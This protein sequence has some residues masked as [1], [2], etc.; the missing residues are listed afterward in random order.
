MDEFAQFKIAAYG[1]WELFLHKQQF[2]YVGRCYAAAI[3]PSAESILDMHPWEAEELIGKVVPAWNKAVKTLFNHDWP[4][5]AILGNDWRHLH[6][7]LIPRY[8]TPR[9]AHGIEFV[10][11]RPKGNYAPY[12]KKEIPLETLLAIKEEIRSKL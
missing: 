1:Y 10:D 6:A 5:V 9:T 2:P 11:P 4:N 7:H 12:D 8:F 3:R